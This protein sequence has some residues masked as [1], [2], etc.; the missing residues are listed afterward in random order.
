MGCAP[1]CAQASARLPLSLISALLLLSLPA[2]ANATA[3]KGVDADGR[4]IYSDQPLPNAE[5]IALPSR[6]SDNE[7]AAASNPQDA[8]FLGPYQQFEILAPV[9]GE[10]LE[11]PDGQVQVSLILDPP[12]EADHRLEVRV[13]GTPV[14]GLDGRTQFVLQGLPP[15]SH[16][17]QATI[18][19]PTGASVALAT[20]VFFNLRPAAPEETGN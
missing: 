6:S 20:Q 9:T 18:L 15:G 5:P 14:A 4:V 1:A 16:Q 11:S 8:G 17:L 19:D 12:L 2:W 10:T 7:T 3:Y 13:D